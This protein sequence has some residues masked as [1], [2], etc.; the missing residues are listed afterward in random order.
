[1]HIKI[2]DTLTL[3]FKKISE[4][5]HSLRNYKKQN[6]TKTQKANNVLKSSIKTVLKKPKTT[7]F[8]PKGSVTGEGRER[9]HEK[10]GKAGG[11]LE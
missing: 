3:S 11:A 1:M 5:L 2:F 7:A 4:G 6:K 9:F 8:K 10:V